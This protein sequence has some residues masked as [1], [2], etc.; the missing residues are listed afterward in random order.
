MYK[1]AVGLALSTLA[2][3]LALACGG[4]GK[5]SPLSGANA[6]GSGGNQTWDIAKADELAHA[7]LLVVGDLPGSGWEVEDDDFDDEPKTAAACADYARLVKEEGLAR[8][9]RAERDFEKAGAGRNDFGTQI[10]SSA[11]V[12]RDAKTASDLLTRF[13]GMLDSGKFIAC[14]EADYGESGIKATFKKGTA[15]QGAPNKGVAMAIDSEIEAAGVKLS[16]HIEQYTWLSGNAIVGVSVNMSKDKFDA[17]LA[18][19]VLAKQEF[20]A[21]DALK[22]V[23]KP[24]T[25]APVTT[26][27]PASNPTPSRS[28]SSSSGIAKPASLAD[29]SSHKY[30][31]KIESSGIDFFGAQELVDLVQQLPGAQPSRAGAP[32]TLEVTGAYARPDKGTFKYTVNGTSFSRT[33]I[34]TQQWTYTSTNVGAPKTVARQSVADLSVAVKSFG[35]VLRD[36]TYMSQMKCSAAESVNGVSARRCGF[37]QAD[38]SRSEQQEF[39]DAF[40]TKSDVRVTI[41]AADVT[42]TSYYLWQAQQDDQIVKFVMEFAGKDTKGTSF[43]ARIEVNVTDINKPVDIVAPR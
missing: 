12:Y 2:I 4:D 8:V 23:R 18:K 40:V 28:S 43:N 19:H 39:I 26:G 38:L 25:S 6:G 11:T 34:G 3:L 13:R 20:A 7:A 9:A 41:R 14:F 35:S 21:A 30:T 16:L 42:K 5:G 36:D 27:R 1:R 32:V 15:S 29:T 24:A 17:D 10:E 22:G 31:I 37:A 33:T